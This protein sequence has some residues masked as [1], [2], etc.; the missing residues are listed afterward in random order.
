MKKAT[1]TKYLLHFKSPAGTSRGTLQHKE[2]WFVKVWNEANPSLFGIGECAVF[3]GLS[4]DDL[5][6]YENKLMECC[7]QINNQTF[8]HKE[9]LLWP[10]IRFG[11]ESALLDLQ[12]GSIRTIFPSSFSQGDDGIPIN[13][14]IWMGSKD[15]IKQQIT[16]KLNAGYRCIKIKIGA[17]QLQDEL[18][19][20]KLIRHEYNPAELEIR[21][22]ANGSFPHGKALEILE[23]FA[24]YTIHSV[25]QPIKAGTP[26]LLS[27]V[28]KHSPIPIALDEELIGKTT[29][30]EKRELLQRTKPAYIIIKPT[31]TGGFAASMEWIEEAKIQNI[32]W[33]VTSALESNVG[34]NV[35]AQWTYSLDVKVTQGLGTGGL[36]TNNIP[37]PLY[38]SKQELRTNKEAKWD[39]SNISFDE[40]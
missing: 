18:D 19:L 38:I 33:W 23:Q 31:L 34:L 7:H 14:L 37:S 35:I 1:Y 24:K 8:L 2:T 29:V 17:I 25:E 40:Q 4:M 28:C 26:D 13:G 5:P 21:L 27:E 39:F 32:G 12:Q 9:L 6:G 16:E 20:L 36:F 11:V 22:D 15:F 30:V 3:K 10:S